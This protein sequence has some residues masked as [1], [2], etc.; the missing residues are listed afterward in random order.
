VV[1]RALVERATQRWFADRLESPD[2]GGGV[3]PRDGGADLACGRCG[4]CFPVLNGQ[5]RCLPSDGLR[6]RLD[7]VVPQAPPAWPPWREPPDG[8]YLGPRTPRTNPRHLSILAARPGPLDV[9]DWGCGTAEYR[10]PVAEVLGHRYVGVDLEGPDADVLCDAHRLPFRS[11]SFDH[12][13]TNAVLEHVA[14]PFV[15]AGEVFRVLRPNGV[16]SGSV[17]FLEPHHGRSHFHLSPDGVVRVLA[18]AGLRV[19]GLWPQEG[20]TVFDSLAE[21]PGPVSGPSRWVLRRV[22]RLERLV[23]SRH[24]H[25]RAIATGRWLRRKTGEESHA[26]R[27]AVAGQVDFLAT[28]P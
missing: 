13:I 21:M 12:V 1:L 24:L 19:D 18:S 28:R 3:A 5:I 4:R 14:N 17:A 9:L 16:L 25:P 15:A 23:R 6:V 10:R 2:C 26:E 22:G 20:W 27:L 7:L 11:A 8:R